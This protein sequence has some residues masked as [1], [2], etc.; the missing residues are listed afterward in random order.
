MNPYISIYVPFHNPEYAEMAHVA[1]ASL[2][3]Q[4]FR[5]FETIVV[6]N[7]TGIPEWMAR[8]RFLMDTVGHGGRKVVAGRFGTLAAA[9]NAAMANSKGEWIVRLDA[10]DELTE[11]ALW[12]YARAI[13]KYPLALAIEGHWVFSGEVQGGGL[14]LHL[15][16]LFQ[17]GGYDELRPMKDGMRICEKMKLVKD[18][19]CTTDNQVYHYHRHANSITNGGSNGH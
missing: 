9:S 13:E 18:D 14:M 10:D 4:T 5:N 15:E 12:E 17:C 1:L 7:D 8:E 2:E 3:S 16:S 11:D 19:I 6:A